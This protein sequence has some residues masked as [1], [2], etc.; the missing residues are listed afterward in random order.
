MRLNAVLAVVLLSGCT[1][2]ERINVGNVGLLINT[3]G[4]SRG[5]QEAPLVSGWVTYNP[6]TQD[7]VEFPTILQTVVWTGAEAVNFGS[8]EGVQIGAD[9]SVSFR[10]DPTKASKFYAKFRQADLEEFA[11]G[12]LRNQVKDALNETASKMVIT[13]LYGESKTQLLHDA[14]GF[15]QKRLAPDGI[16]VDQLTFNGP[17]LLPENVQASI[18][19]T[20]ALTQQAEQARNTVARIEAE[21][22]QRIAQAKGEA[23]AQQTKAAADAFARKARADADAYAN[24]KES[25]GEAEGIKLINEARAHANTKLRQSLSKDVIEFEKIKKWDGKLPTIGSGTQTIMDLRSIASQ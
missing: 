6:L 7:V 21:A 4:E 3:G 15:V 10:I 16:L 1:G 20:I 25:E 13:K 23:E 19:Q 8:V 9:V 2:C 24:V 11:H 17:L 22:Q 14:H 12:F 18:N 5:L